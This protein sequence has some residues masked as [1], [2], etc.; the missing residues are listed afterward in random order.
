M[1]IKCGVLIKDSTD[2][3]LELGGTSA[4][5]SGCTLAINIGISFRH[6]GTEHRPLTTAPTHP[7]P[8]AIALSYSILCA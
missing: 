5:R 3:S 7:L 4:Y 2:E 1:S 8:A 6:L